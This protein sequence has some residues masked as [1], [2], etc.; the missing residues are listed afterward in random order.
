MNSDC[1][2]LDN[3]SYCLVGPCRNPTRKILGKVVT[4]RRLFLGR[5]LLLNA[6]FSFSMEELLEKKKPSKSWKRRS[7]SSSRSDSRSISR[8]HSRSPVNRRESRK[9]R[10]FESMRGKPGRGRGKKQGR[11]RGRGQKV[12][13]DVPKQSGKKWM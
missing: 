2:S 7:K 4:T 6:F 1:K 13:K 8:S 12:N 10:Q 3:S 11:G 5:N 9:E